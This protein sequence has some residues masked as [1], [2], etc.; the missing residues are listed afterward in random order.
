[1]TKYISSGNNNRWYSLF[2]FLYTYRE[3]VFV[4]FKIST[5]HSANKT[6][7]SLIG[8]SCVVYFCSTL[9]ECP[10]AILTCLERENK[11]NNKRLPKCVWLHNRWWITR[12]V[13]V[14][15]S[16]VSMSTVDRTADH[17]H[18]FFS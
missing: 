15:P 13:F 12:D 6:G 7:G 2:N 4:T 10:L 18:L 9:L 1:M 16:T 8:N 3:F 14:P 17:T 5:V 11:M